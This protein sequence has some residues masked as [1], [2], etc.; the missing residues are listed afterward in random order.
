[1]EEKRCQEEAGLKAGRECVCVGA[2]GGDDDDRDIISL[3][4]Q[5]ELSLIEINI[6][7]FRSGE[8]SRPIT[9]EEIGNAAEF[10][11]LKR[12][13]EMGNFIVDCMCLI[14]NRNH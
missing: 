11:S 2:G 7:D 12:R 5:Y 14:Q 9:K 10:L 6:T 3:N 1:M 13:T 4:S 8:L